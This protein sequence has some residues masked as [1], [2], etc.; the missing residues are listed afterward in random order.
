MGRRRYTWSW[1]WDRVKGRRG[2]RTW[3]FRRSRRWH[4][5]MRAVTVS[6][7]IAAAINIRP[8]PLRAPTQSTLPILRQAIARKGDS[9]G[10]CVRRRRCRH[11][12]QGTGLLQSVCRKARTFLRWTD[13]HWLQTSG[14]FVTFAIQSVER[15]RS[16]CGF[17]P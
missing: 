17:E 11:I 15:G 14:R 4:R 12:P 7:R 13:E 8:R 3:H 1:R 5:N 16:R 2:D 9:Q 10:I 6:G